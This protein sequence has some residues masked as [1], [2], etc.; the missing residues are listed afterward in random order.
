M[1]II[2]DALKKAEDSKK[3][4]PNMADFPIK[5]SRKKNIAPA[6][7]ISLL[8]IAGVVKGSLYLIANFDQL[9]KNISGKITVK[10]NSSQPQNAPVAMVTPKEV[11]AVSSAVVSL[12]SSGGQYNLE[13][14][15]YDGQTPLAIING[16]MVAKDDKIDNWQVI[17]ITASDVELLNLNDNTKQSLSF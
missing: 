14:I 10:S 11:P 7:I 5:S 6:L 8:V 1:S 4:K 3:E 15:V 9:K 12:A 16:K 2:Y 13:G 17:S